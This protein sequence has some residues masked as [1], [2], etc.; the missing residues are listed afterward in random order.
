[1]NILVTIPFNEKQ[2]NLI[3]NSAQD[4]KFIYVEQN[5][6]NYEQVQ[7]ADIIIGTVDPLLINKSKRLKLLQV[8]SA[9]VDRYVG[10]DVLAEAT[11]L[12]N[13]RGAYG[14]SV[15][16]HMF[17]MLLTLMKK[18]NLYRDDQFAARWKDYKEVS[19]LTNKRV[20]IVGLGNIGQHFAKLVKA[21]DA[22]VIGLE[23]EDKK[24][25]KYVDEIKTWN[26]ID[27]LLP[28]I[29]I[30]ASFLPSSP[31]TYK[32]YDSDFFDKL[33]NKA[34]FLNGGR[35]N[36][37]NQEAL[38]EAL[39]NNDIYAAGLDVTDPEPLTKNHPLWQQKNVLITPHVSGGYHLDDTLDK[40]SEIA[41][42]NLYNYLNDK[43]LI[44]IMDVSTGLSK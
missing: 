27:K 22:Y 14:K 33:S 35:G 2:K 43:P 37:L 36:A 44:N 10:N 32:I 12:T 34:I 23:K 4:C 30:V 26:E 38:V 20:L 5:L 39:K 11:I 41:A 3:E 17:A 31:N 9:G 29:D 8:N 15:S 16:E 25:P 21:F 13:A 28:T 18:I 7:N 42:I 1:M 40:I 19:S 6:A 24:P